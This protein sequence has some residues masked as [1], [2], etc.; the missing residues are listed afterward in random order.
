MVIL[1]MVNGLLWRGRWWGGVYWVRKER[2]LEGV[3]IPWDTL[4]GMELFFFRWDDMGIVVR[5]AGNVPLGLGT[6]LDG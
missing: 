6:D 1:E 3:R 4:M 2:G 5:D